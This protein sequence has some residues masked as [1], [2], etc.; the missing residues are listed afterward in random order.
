MPIRIQRATPAARPAFTVLEIENDGPGPGIHVDI[1]AGTVSAYVRDI[2]AEGNA[3]GGSYAKTI[4]LPRPVID[5]LV[6]AFLAEGQSTGDLP[7]GAIE[8]T[9]AVPTEG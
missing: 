1:D 3:S 9:A 2:D 6:D 7:P 4:P 5:A 8:K